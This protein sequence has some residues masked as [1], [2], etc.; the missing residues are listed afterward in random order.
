MKNRLDRIDTWLRGL[1]PLGFISVIGIAIYIPL[2]VLLPLYYYFP[3][4]YVV[5]T[6]DEQRFLFDVLLFVL[7]APF[8]ETLIFQW[9]VIKSCRFLFKFNDIVLV[10]VSAVIFGTFHSPFVTQC[11]AFLTGLLLA[12]SF[13]IYEKKRFPAVL[14]VTILHVIRNL[15]IAFPDLG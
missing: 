3:D 5:E 11:M 2:I 10:L 6:P 12:Y 7:V 14:M 15:P 13:V 9:M 1:S 8:I 4:G